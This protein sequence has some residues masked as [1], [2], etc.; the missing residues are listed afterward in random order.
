L[1]LEELYKL[2]YAKYPVFEKDVNNYCKKFSSFKTLYNHMVN[3]FEIETINEII[4]DNFNTYFTKIEQIVL[5][6]HSNKPMESKNSM[7]Q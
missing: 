1:S 2:E 5:N 4:T 6:S 7:K 3:A